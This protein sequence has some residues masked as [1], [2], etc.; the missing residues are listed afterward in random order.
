MYNLTP[1]SFPCDRKRVRPV[2]QRRQR[3][4]FIQRAMH[5]QD[6]LLP[7]WQACQQE[8]KSCAAQ[9][10]NP[11]SACLFPGCLSLLVCHLCVHCHLNTLLLLHG[12]PPTVGW[13]ARNVAHLFPFVYQFQ[14]HL[15][16]VCILYSFTW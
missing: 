15:P 13:P 14:S 5:R 16:D 7:G 6:S 11:A 1:H 12:Y 10:H 3:R 4:F 2:L 8:G 9:H